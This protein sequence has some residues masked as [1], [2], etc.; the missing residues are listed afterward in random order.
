MEL[1][2]QDPGNIR[3]G[4]VAHGAYNVVGL[5]QPLSPSLV[6]TRPSSLISSPVACNTAHIVFAEL[7]C[8]AVCSK[9]SA[10]RQFPR[11]SQRLRPS[12]PFAQ[13]NSGFSR[14]VRRREW[15]VRPVHRH[16]R[17]LRRPGGT[18]R[19]YAEMRGMMGLAPAAVSEHG[20]L[21]AY[22]FPGG[23]GAGVD[24]D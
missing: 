9:I 22:C 14:P 13:V 21:L 15:Y 7:V 17:R 19:V 24:G 11:A 23:F 2:S 5:E 8:I 3:I 6:M 10:S 12:C 16:C 20:V 4:F 1:P 18:F